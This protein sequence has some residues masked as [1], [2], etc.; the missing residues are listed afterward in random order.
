MSRGDTGRADGL[1]PESAIASW[2]AYLVSRGSLSD[3]DADELED[4]LCSQIDALR[5]AGLDAD[6][7]VL[8]A[9]KRMGRQD[10]IAGEYAREN[11][12]RLWKQLVVAG[13]PARPRRLDGGVIMLAFAVL[14]ALLAKLPWLLGAA[15]A[16]AV[17]GGAVLAMATLAV[18]V[19]WRTRPPRALVAASAVG[20]AVIFVLALAY[21]FGGRGDTLVIFGLHAPIVLWL[22]IGLLYAG[23]GWRTAAGRM[24]FVRFTGEWIVYLALIALGGGVLMGITAAVF[25]A[26]G[27]DPS[28]VLIEWVAPCGAAGAAAVAAWLVDSKQEVIEN[29]APVL[30]RVFTPLF[31][32]AVLAMLAGAVVTGGFGAYREVLIVVDV[33]LVV[34]TGLVLYVLSAQQP[35]ARPGWTERLQLLL[36]LA[37]FALNGFALAA[38]LGRIGDGGFTP[39]RVVALGVNLV[40]LV[41]LA[42]TAW[43]LARRAFRADASTRRLLAWQTGYLPV[44][45]AWALAAAVVVPPIFA[46]A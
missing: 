15:I 30:G 37:A 32:I 39:N 21:P 6:E 16:P 33:L 18:S 8:I 25:S 38:M 35:T 22:L 34:V 26:L 7:A 42:G 12:R 1:D 10:E 41:G 13:S 31:T 14:A 29:M 4:H 36:V 24:D 23:A 20:F 5:A 40:L 46:F 19:A 2:R 44:Y 28:T 9:V 27:A 45:G 11:S 3:G 43:L 17:L